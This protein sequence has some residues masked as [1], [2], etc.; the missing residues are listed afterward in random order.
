[1]SDPVNNAKPDKIDRGWYYCVGVYCEGQFET[2]EMALI[3]A[4]EYYF[5][6]PME[7]IDLMEGYRPSL[8]ASD[9]IDTYDISGLLGSISE[10][11]SEKHGCDDY[12]ISF[13][14][15]DEQEEEL[16]GLVKKAVDEWQSKNSIVVYSHIIKAITEETVPPDGVVENEVGNSEQDG[17]FVEAGDDQNKS[18]T[19]SEGAK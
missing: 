19:I 5:D 13:D 1:M 12:Y 2:R 10:D 17:K 7:P 8:R 18:E 4:R 9:F 14:C 11:A 3:K 15:T 6:S 16:L